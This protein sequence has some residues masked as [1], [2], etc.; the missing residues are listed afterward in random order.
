MELWAI[1][2]ILIV[3]VI[4]HFSIQLSDDIQV[5]M[6]PAI[7]EQ[8]SN[9][10]F[11]W[12]RGARGSNWSDQLRRGGQYFLVHHAPGR[13]RRTFAYRCHGLECGGRIIR[14]KENRGP[15]RFVPAS[16]RG[17]EKNFNCP[18]LRDRIRF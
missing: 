12:T 16:I 9:G 15:G 5:F 18:V 4:Y 8:I 14:D 1:A 6:D 10:L 3:V 7:S 17:G 11:V 13:R 2:G